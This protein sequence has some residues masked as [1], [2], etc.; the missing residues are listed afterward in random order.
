VLVAGVS[1]RE[2]HAGP[3]SLSVAPYGDGWS[4]SAYSQELGL[5]LEAGDGFK[6]AEEARDAAVAWARS[7]AQGILDGLARGG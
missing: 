1:V 6:S 2:F 5:T 4:W 3:V 7:F